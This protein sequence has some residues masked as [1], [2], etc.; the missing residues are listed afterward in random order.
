M[1][2]YISQQLA[3]F[4]GAALLGAVLGLAYDL[5]R[6]VRRRWQRLL[7]VCDV[8]FCLAVAAGSIGYTLRAAGG[9]LRLYLAVGM[10]LGAGLYFLAFSAL[11]RPLWDFWIDVAA[12]FLHLCA[13][14]LQLGKIFLQKVARRLKKLFHFWYKWVKI[15]NYKWA[16]ILVRRNRERSRSHER[17]TG[18][19]PQVKSGAAGIL[20]KVVLVAVLAY[21]GAT[22]LHLQNQL[23]TAR[24]QE[25]QLAAQVQE[26]QDKNNALRSDI[27]ASG[28]PD[29]LEDVARSELGM[30]ESGEKVFYETGS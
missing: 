15:L 14:P 18:T 3:L 5:L 19:S 29:K 7:A 26:L 24:E 12:S 25:T 2:I 8:L 20:T 10:V 9:E 23:Q 17:S 16:F 11:L 1:E 13:L 22:L 28:D 30:V 21:A 27:A 4:P 6:S